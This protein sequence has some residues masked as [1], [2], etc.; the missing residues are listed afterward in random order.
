MNTEFLTKKPW[1][2]LVLLG[3]EYALLGWYLSVHHI[4]WL[5]GT[6]IVVITFGVAWKSNPILK[7]LAWFTTGGLLVVLGVSLLVSLV[8]A[9]TLTNPVSLGLVLLPLITLLYA[10]LEMQAADFKQVDIFLWSVM[11]TG[12]GLGL[13][14]VIDLFVTPSMRY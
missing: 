2:A 12:L 6:F 14:E 4:F 13:G 11:M 1:L 9:L 5:I 3:G 10:R 7:V 8:V